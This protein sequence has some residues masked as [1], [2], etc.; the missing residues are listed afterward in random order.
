MLQFTVINGA[1]NVPCDFV[2]RYKVDY[3]H[4]TPYT[5][6]TITVQPNS[7]GEVGKYHHF[8]LN[9]IYSFFLIPFKFVDSERTFIYFSFI[10][11]L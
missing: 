8:D 9:I 6:K 4:N 7:V 5:T 10:I 11:Y 1:N 2:L 3:N